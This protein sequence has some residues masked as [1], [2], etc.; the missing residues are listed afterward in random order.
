MNDVI[1]EIIKAAGINNVLTDNEHLIIYRKGSIDRMEKIPLCVVK[2]TDENIISRVL[3]IASKYHLNVIARGGGSSPTGAV[4]PVENTIVL[5]MRPLNNIRVN[6]KD[7]YV[8][9][10]AGATLQEVNNECM[11]YGYFFPPDPSS[12]STATVGGA[13]NENSGGM[14]CARYG[15]VKDWVLKLD[16][17]LANGEETSFGE[18]IYKN[19]GGFNLVDLICG[20]EGTLCIVK[21]AYLKILGLPGKIYRI[22]GFYDNIDDAMDAILKIR[23]LNPLILEFADYYGIAAANKIKRFNYPEVNGG[24]V[25]VD[26]DFSQDDFNKIKN[27]IEERAMKIVVPQGKEFDEIFEIRRIAFAAPGLLYPGFIDGDIVVPISRLSEAL[28]GID[29]IRRK[30]NVY[31]ATCGHAGDGNLHPQVG[32]DPGEQWNNAVSAMNEI[33]MLAIKLGGSVSGEHGIGKTKIGMLKEQFR[34]KNQEKSL[35]FMNK[36]KKIFDPDNILNRG[37]FID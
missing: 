3:K 25:L 6:F 18:T 12:V 24:M 35:Y 5:D 36:I 8:E 21:K 31:I 14:R 28:K 19:R 34:Y 15:V 17:V 9:A 26:T 32:A 37:D 13:V 16:C 2:I 30:Y 20:S 22:A 7:G 23:M 4:V 1:N 29:D 27:I 11:K 10:Y 33:N